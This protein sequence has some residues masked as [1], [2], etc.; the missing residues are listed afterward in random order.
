MKKRFTD[1]D[2]WNDPWF[3]KMPCLYKEFWRFLC[4]RCDAAGVWKVDLEGAG[5][6]LGENISE[7]SALDIFNTGKQRVDILSPEKWHI[8]EFV[9]FQYGEL[10]PTCKPHISVMALLREHKI[11]GYAKGIH[12]LKEEEKEKEKEQERLYKDIYSIANQFHDKYTQGGKCFF[13][14]KVLKGLNVCHCDPYQEAFHKFK[15]KNKCL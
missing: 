4:D 8:V 14:G 9:K 5:F 6:S 1:C 11:K 15:E 7:K 12:T 3:R 2:I 10:S 13:C